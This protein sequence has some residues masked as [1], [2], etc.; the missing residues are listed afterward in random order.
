MMNNEQ[1]NLKISILGKS[2][3]I[4]T[5]EPSESVLLAAKRVDKLL[6]EKLDNVSSKNSEQVAIAVALELATELIRKER[7]LEE[8]DLKAIEIA[9]RIP[10]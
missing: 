3:V 7:T 4:A 9:T 2:Y 8:Y 5:D 6:T 10:D 1:K